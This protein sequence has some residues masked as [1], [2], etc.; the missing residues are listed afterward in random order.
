M[1]MDCC[2]YKESASAEQLFAH[3]WRPFSCEGTGEECILFCDLRELYRV[4]ATAVL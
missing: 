3:R 4:E 1:R 2:T